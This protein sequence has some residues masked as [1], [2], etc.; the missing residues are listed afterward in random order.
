MKISHKEV[1]LTEFARE[2]TLLLIGQSYRNSF[3][4]PGSILFILFL[5]IDRKR[6]S[7]FKIVQSKYLSNKLCTENSVTIE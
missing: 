4:E 1:I 7:N 3:K 2:N 6:G 5:I